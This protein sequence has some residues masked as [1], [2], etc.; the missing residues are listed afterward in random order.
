MNYFEIFAVEP[1][2]GIDKNHL[3]KKY[4]QLQAKFHP[5]RATSN[6]EKIKFLDESTRI[7]AGYKILMDDYLRAEYLLEVNNKKITDDNSKNILSPED[8]EVIWMHNEQLDE[9]QSKEDLF[10]LEKKHLQ[11]QATLINDLL[12]SF[13]NKNISK[14]L[15]LTVKLKYLTNLVK[16]IRL[17]IRDANN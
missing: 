11:D 12:S 10:S 5:D 9:A 7:N 16:N 13:D 17:K 3:K 2:Y 8:L 4:L 1:S 6:A 14:A 15:E